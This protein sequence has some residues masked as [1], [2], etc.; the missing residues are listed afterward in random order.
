MSIIYIWE[1]NNSVLSKKKNETKA[2]TRR[3]RNVFIYFLYHMNSSMPGMSCSAHKRCSS[4]AVSGWTLCVLSLWMK[5]S[6][7]WLCDVMGDH[8]AYSTRVHISDGPPTS[9]CKGEKNMGGVRHLE[10]AI[11]W[12][13]MRLHIHDV[14]GSVGRTSQILSLIQMTYMKY[15]CSGHFTTSFPGH[16]AY[17]ILS[18]VHKRNAVLRKGNS[19][20]DLFKYNNLHFNQ[21]HYRLDALFH[22]VYM[23]PWSKTW[24]DP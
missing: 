13:G 2:G 16:W 22:V 8:N 20:I 1:K 6:S 4:A 5:L 12:R 19:N 14:V 15:D 17:L 18:H 7:C 9:V 24:I 10:N 21:D 23:I 11:C 3:K